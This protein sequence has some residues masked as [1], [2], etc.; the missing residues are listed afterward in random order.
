[1]YRGLY[2]L[3][4][5]IPKGKATSYGAVGRSLERPI[6]G[7]LVGRAMAMCPPDVPWWRVVAKD[8]S[9]ATA[10][11][12]PEVAEEQRRRLEAEGVPLDG[13]QVAREGMLGADELYAL[14]LE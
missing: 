11:R 4:G 8:G 14:T 12:S 2:E 6:S 1:M 10:K 9:F 5:R 13:L 7:Y 3:V